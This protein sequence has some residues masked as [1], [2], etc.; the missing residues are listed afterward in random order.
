MRVE[1]H[2]PIIPER[3]MLLNIARHF[4]GRKGSSCCFKPEDV[5]LRRA[6]WLDP[7][8]LFVAVRG[9]EPP[10]AYTCHW[11]CEL[12]YRPLHCMRHLSD[13]ISC[14]YL[15]ILIVT[16]SLWHCP[17]W[18]ARSLQGDASTASPCTLKFETC[19]GYGNQRLSLVYGILLAH[20]TGRAAVAPDF[21][22]DG[23]QTAR[24]NM[25]PDMAN[26]LPFQEAYDLP[27]L[28]QAL[29]SLEVVE[30]ISA[31]EAPP[32]AS[33]TQLSLEQ[34]T[35]AV[36]ALESHSCIGTPHVQVDCPLFKLPPTTIEARKDM[37][38]AVLDAL[39]PAQRLQKYVNEAVEKLRHQSKSG[40]YQVYCHAA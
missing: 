5:I 21:L 33:Y 36:M 1:Y 30:L 10:T 15:L 8:A 19:N 26:V 3:L 17:C 20:A 23:T 6:N 7:G 29:T 14:E 13:R 35:D 22:L 2:G 34:H 39:Q 9:K 31:G 16:L 25:R 11:I 27:K 37:L 38:W 28:Q 4:L 18:A 40:E 24:N 32:A 12:S